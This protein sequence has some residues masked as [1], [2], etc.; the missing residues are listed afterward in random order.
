MYFE[1]KEALEKKQEERKEK[2]KKMTVY[3]TEEELRAMTTEELEEYRKRLA[4]Q[5]TMQA[6]KC[7]A[8]C[9]QILNER[10]KEA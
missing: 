10:E 3:P 9:I 4:G 2:I 8:T 6:I 7:K 5:T 1:W